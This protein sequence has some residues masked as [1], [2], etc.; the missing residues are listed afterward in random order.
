MQNP[1]KAA[2]V[3]VIRTDDSLQN[4]YK[5]T[6]DHREVYALQSGEYA[7]FL[8]NPGHHAI[9]VKCFGGFVPVMWKQEVKVYFAPK[10][11][12]YFLIS[13]TLKCAGIKRISAEEGRFS[14]SS[15]R[16]VSK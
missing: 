15:R 10:K 13:P 11:R 16:E 8:V 14:V 1:T 5:V 3:Y 6:L 12:Y 4:T 9:G 7:K 2:S